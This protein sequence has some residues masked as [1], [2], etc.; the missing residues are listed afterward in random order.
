MT[1]WHTIF[2]LCSHHDDTDT[3]SHVIGVPILNQAS[4]ACIIPAGDVCRAMF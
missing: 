1:Y 2:L 4:A 3:G